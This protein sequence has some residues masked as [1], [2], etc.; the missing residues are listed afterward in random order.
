ML[1]FECCLFKVITIEQALRKEVLSLMEQNHILT[2]KLKESSRDEERKEVQWVMSEQVWQNNQVS[3]WVSTNAQRAR[4]SL[5]W[6]ILL[7]VYFV[8]LASD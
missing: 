8:C 4:V 5:L 6:N 7:F 2:S 3:E 1:I